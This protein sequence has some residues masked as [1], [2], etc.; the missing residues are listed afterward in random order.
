MK[1]IF[2][3]PNESSTQF[4]D[5][6]FIGDDTEGFQKR[7]KDLID[8]TY[9]THLNSTAKGSVANTMNFIGRFHNATE[10]K[11]DSGNH[12]IYK[13]WEQPLI[14]FLMQSK[15]GI[16]DI[17]VDLET[18]TSTSGSD[19]GNDSIIPKLRV[20]FKKPHGLTTGDELK[21]L[22]GNTTSEWT[23]YD[24][25]T[26]DKIFAQVINSTEIHL[27]NVAA[28]STTN[29]LTRMSEFTLGRMDNTK[30]DIRTFGTG[31][32]IIRR[33]TSAGAGTVLRTELT[34]GGVG[35]V[36]GDTIKLKQTFHNT[37]Q[38]GTVNS[39]TPTFHLKAVPGTT[40]SFLLFTDSS[41][42]TPAT[43]NEQLIK[44]AT[45]KYT[46]A[47]TITLHGGTG[48]GDFPCSYSDWGISDS[49]KANLRAQIQPG[50]GFG[51]GF[52][53]IK[54]TVNS[55]TFTGNSSS[56]PSPRTV[57]KA[58]PTSID[59]TDDFA[60]RAFSNSFEIASIRGLSSHNIQDFVLADAG[61]GVDVDIEIQF[62]NPARPREGNLFLQ[63]TGR[64][65]T[66]GMHRTLS[67]N[68]TDADMGIIQ[69]GETTSFEVASANILNPGNK[70]F[71][72]QTG[73][74]TFTAGARYAGHYY[75][76]GDTSSTSGNT[77][78]ESMPDDSTITVNSSGFITGFSFT[79]SV[80]RG[81]FANNEAHYFPIIAAA[82]T[83][84][85]PAVSTAAQ[86]DVFDL[87]T[88]WDT[89]AFSTLKT[90]P[91][92][93]LPSSIQMKYNQPNQTT[94]SQNGVKYVRNLGFTKWQMEVTYPPMTESQFRLYHSAAQKAKGQFVP[95][96]FDIIKSNNTFFLDY[97]D[98]NTTTNVR[99]K[100]DST[101]SN[102]VVLLEGFAN[103][104]TI[105]EGE[106]MIMGSNINGNIH[107]ITNSGLSNIYGEFKARL[108]YPIGTAM[109]ASQTAFLKPEHFV[110]TLG[111]D[112][113]EYAKDTNGFYYVKLKL[114][115]DQYK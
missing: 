67:N 43:L 73:A 31:D 64:Q 22:T 16:K 55:G 29:G 36:E 89:N 80:F 57:T 78:S 4:I 110:V 59:Y 70:T 63:L 93:V 48:A 37:A 76:A 40:F 60:W 25:G 6:N 69:V 56:P 35:L 45:R 27:S 91:D 100:D 52:C 23:N 19:S 65:G 75:K 66:A 1:D 92:T 111:E 95:F 38:T 61:S 88:E 104:E 82:D 12:T 7:I 114:D 84:S 98:A 42:S 30:Y 86:E 20:E 39:I 47:G 96:Q 106:I 81:T 3:Y 8:G 54:A 50:E 51:S 68:T 32:R 115:L 15:S 105:N 109:T 26:G 24:G 49:E 28:P 13:F 90:W 85:A 113:F 71:F 46:S 99:L 107:T 79:D 11:E 62:I 9:K 97:H 72:K 77:S 74:S 10:L 21:I 17:T 33:D 2:K 41:F 102:N 18:I 112:G 83:Y 87:D 94:L 44:T 34:A 53:R 108:A 58:I 101:A 103:N 5:P 14:E